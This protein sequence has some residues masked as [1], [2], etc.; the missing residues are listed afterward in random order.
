MSPHEG[1]ERFTER[2]LY[3]FMTLFTK[4][5]ALSHRSIFAYPE[6]AFIFAH[7]NKIQVLRRRPHIR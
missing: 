7:G 1:Y 3:L 6:N 5:I 2:G 4:T